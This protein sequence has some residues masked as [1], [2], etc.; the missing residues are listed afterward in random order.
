LAFSLY[1]F[2]LLCCIAFCFVLFCFVL[3]CF[4]PEREK[5]YWGKLGQ[6]GERLVAQAKA[7][8]ASTFQ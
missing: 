6:V 2:L 3:F 5:S 8:R 7:K 4:S 1:N